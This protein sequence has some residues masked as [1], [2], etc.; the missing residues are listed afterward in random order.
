[1]PAVKIIFLRFQAMIKLSLIKHFFLIS[2]IFNSCKSAFKF[3][4]NNSALGLSS[5]NSSLILN[6]NIT[7]FNGTLNL[8][9]ATGDNIKS[10]VAETIS[11][12]NGSVKTGTSNIDISGGSY[13][14]QVSGTDQITLNNGHIL[15][16]SAGT[17]VQHDIIITS[18]AIASIIGAPTFSSPITLDAAGTSFLNLGIQH[19]LN[20]NINY[21]ASGGTVN[22]TD[23][24]ALQDGIR[25]VPGGSGTSILDLDYHTLEIGSSAA[26][27]AWTGILTFKHAQ[28]IQLNGP[29]N[30]TG[31]WSFVNSGE[32]STINGNG[33]ILDL[34]GG[35]KLTVAVN[36]TLYIN[37][38][39]IKGLGIGAGQLDPADDATTPGTIV[40]SNVTLD[41]DANYLHDI[42]AIKIRG[43]NCRIIVGKPAGGAP[44]TF[45]VDVNA[46]LLGTVKEMFEVD[47]QALIYETLGGFNTNPFLKD[48]GAGP[49]PL[50]LTTDYASNGGVIRS[51][52]SD[53]AIVN[54]VIYATNNTQILTDNYDLFTN[55]A[56][57]DIAPTNR[58]VVNNI[59]GGARTLTIDGSGYVWTFP[60]N[61]TAKVLKIAADTTVTLENVILENFSLDNVEFMHATSSVLKFGTN[62]NISLKRNLSLPAS[63]RNL[64]ISGGAKILGNGHT[65]TVTANQGIYVEASSL[66]IFNTILN[67]QHI[68]GI[69]CS[70][71]ASEIKLQDSKVI[72]NQAGFSCFDNGSTNNAGLTI[73]G[74]CNIES[75]VT[76]AMD[77]ITNF[78]F[79]T[80][81]TITI[82]PTGRLNINR[83]INFRYMPS[84]TLNLLTPT[85]TEF[86]RRHIDFIA[87]SST[88]S[89]NGCTFTSTT[90]P[91]RFTKGNLIID[92]KVQL[93]ADFTTVGLEAEI[94]SAVNVEILAA[95]SLN[96]DGK[97][98]YITT[99]V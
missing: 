64:I 31:T 87:P 41:L 47:G 68:T 96:I 1:M 18:S 63:G 75:A 16:I 38:L 76:N 5:T 62:A 36:H 49:V 53:V 86:T 11:F 7:N 43:D 65:I 69:S 74:I 39:H 28:D 90:T 2:L 89:L 32:I 54:T 83:G 59:S 82:M 3:S 14:P 61:T 79:I 21:G 10:T 99:A 26:S 97:V 72:I 80:T 51:A 55:I 34:S 57:P 58:I 73:D 98:K 15:S 81:G 12:A 94:G 46:S 95:G 24:L 50:V 91:V 70:S 71:A 23:D 30:L 42:G 56:T 19:K 8:R 84:P 4:G 22:L 88:L 52:I 93:T 44:Y 17:T 20:Q 60:N 27:S 66:N 6:Q 78:D 9:T 67:I 77:G 40:L 33:N 85:P 29:V 25:L 48:V 37:D 35:G 92:N 45:T 13:N